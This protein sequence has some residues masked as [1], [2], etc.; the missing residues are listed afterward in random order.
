MTYSAGMQPRKGEPPTRLPIQK[1]DPSH[2]GRQ[3][4]LL[5]SR[6][7]GGPNGKYLQELEAPVG[8]KGI[9]LGPG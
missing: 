6:M 7:P 9:W 4:D 8:F 1:Q 5:T 2:V 3:I